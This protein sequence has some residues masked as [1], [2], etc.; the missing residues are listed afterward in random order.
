MRKGNTM[1]ADPKTVAELNTALTRLTDR[2]LA[3]FV[4]RMS[5]LAHSFLDD[6]RQRVAD[7]FACMCVLAA[8]QQDRR[9]ELAEHARTQLDGD[10][11]GGI[12]G[13]DDFPPAR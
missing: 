12:T 11:I 13:E 2:E 5:G 8:E 9:K 7:V 10:E 4:G 1:T 6:D 3:V